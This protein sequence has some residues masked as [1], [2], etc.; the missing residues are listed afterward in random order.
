MSCEFAIAK[1][2]YTIAYS[3]DRKKIPI[4]RVIF[5]KIKKYFFGG[6][7]MKKEL[8]NIANCLMNLSGI[9]VS[10]NIEQLRAY[11]SGELS[12]MEIK[13]MNSLEADLSFIEENKQIFKILTVSLAFALTLA[14]N[15][16]T[17]HAATRS[18]EP[19]GQSLMTTIQ[20]AGKWVILIKALIEII[21]DGLQ[22]GESYKSMGRTAM[23]Y[24]LMYSSLFF[25]PWVFDIVRDYFR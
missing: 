18:L 4:F 20:E 21:K 2:A 6:I 22:G 12:L 14:T 5:I 25:L 16:V 23:T 8:R 9:E 11:R 17:A 1:L 3:A 10:M 19:L 13:F 15:S 24:I 7:I